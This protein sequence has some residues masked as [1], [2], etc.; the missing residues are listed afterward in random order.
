MIPKII[1]Y[2]WFGKQEKTELMKKCIASWKKYCPDFEIFEWNEENFKMDQY[3]YAR[4][5]YD[6]RKWAFLSDFV[7]LLVVHEYGGVYFDTDVE[8]IKSIDNLLKNE[9]FYG[10]ENDT[11]INTGQGFGAIPKHKTVD[12]MLQKYY[13]LKAADDGK[14]PLI[15]CPALNTEALISMGLKLNGDFQKING[16]TILPV[17]YLNPHD[18][19]SGKI[20]ITKNT[21]SIHHYA[22]SWQS[23]EE[24]RNNIERHN[25]KKIREKYGKTLADI[26]SN[27]FWS[28]KENGGK[29]VLKTVIDRIL[30]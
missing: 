29:G 24:I 6:N 7:R 15:V 8:L 20:K 1:H 22:A 13:E 17:D 4:Y 27:L 26:Y 11:N 23:S 10:F 28:K 12:A 9:A 16:A 5:C 19:A 2:C 3:P 30:K 14:Y 25:Y 21:Y 18:W